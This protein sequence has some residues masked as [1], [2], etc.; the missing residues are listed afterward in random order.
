[1]KHHDS[2]I[3]TTTRRGFLRVLTSATGI[4]A[5]AGV[6]TE[7]TGGEPAT[8]ESDAHGKAMAALKPGAENIVILLY[9]GFTALDAI[10][11]EY[12]LSTMA[13]AKVRF[14][15]KTPAPVICETGFAITP[16]LSFDDCPEAPDLLL[17]PGGS[18]GTLAAMQ[19]AATIGFLKSRGAASKLAGSVC[20][21]SI[22]L[23]AAGLLRGYEATSHWQT[24]EL[25]PLCGARPSAKRVVF[26]RDRVTGAGVT[27]GLDLALELVRKF[28]GDF[29]AKGVQ[30]LAQYDP[31][32]PFPNA[33]DPAKADADVVG[34][35]NA[36]HKPFVG[37]MGNAVRTAM[38]EGNPK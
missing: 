30:L 16:N 25:L 36:M 7:S 21:G 2:P 26:D 13:G 18:A 1:M 15:A 38:E 20:T 19:D 4:A 37:Q 24:L 3:T 28:R 8:A 32:P 27:A 12:I 35:L 29:Y 5:A 14:V 23:G 34:L 33:G 31:R 22:L 10:G 9:P 6:T 11:P 17:V